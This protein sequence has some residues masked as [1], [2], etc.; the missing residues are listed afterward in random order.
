M[1]GTKLI[2]SL[3][4]LLSA[5]A[6]AETANQDISPERLVVQ[7]KGVV[8]SFCAYGTERNLAKLEFLDSSQY[9]DGVLLDINTHRITLAL[10]PE[11]PVRYA[12]I[13][14]A[15][16]KGGYDPVVYYAVLKGVIKESLGHYQLIGE[17]NGQVYTL[18]TSIDA[19][20]LL[21]KQVLVRTELN[22]EQAASAVEGQPTRLT[23]VK[24]EP[25]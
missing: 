16:V 6:L 14:E 20:S 7:V 2:A 11:K 17:A 1:K 13:A 18:P 5:G 3:A 12:S 23:K 22:A 25:Q 21:G 24:L 10:L 4:L 8:C 19:A 15:I 9:G